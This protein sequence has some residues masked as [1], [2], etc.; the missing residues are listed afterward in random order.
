MT[1]ALALIETDALVIGAGPAGLFQAF[2][3]G[4]LGIGCHIVDVLHEPGGQVAELYGDKPIY[5]IPGL[6]GCT[7]NALITGLREQ[8]RPFNPPMHLGQEVTDL[9]VH[10]EAAFDLRTSH[11]QHFHARSVLIAAGVGAF[12]PRRLKAPGLDAF[13]ST[14]QLLYGQDPRV[15]E[16][17][18]KAVVVAGGDALAIDQ[19]IALADLPEDKRPAAITLMHRRAVLQADAQRLAVFQHLCTSG[20]AKLV[21]G[22]VSEVEVEQKRM[23]ALVVTAPDDTRIHLPLDALVVALGLS[24]RLGPLADWGLELT[25]KQVPVDTAHFMTR[26]PG[27]YAVGDINLYPGKKRLI[28]S[29]F[30]EATLAAFAVAERLY[31]DRRTAL[32]YTSSSSELQQRLGV[33]STR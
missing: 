28:L 4:L 17:A 23:R 22:Q 20:S 18:G 1:S 29:A 3:L 24:P 32:Q 25:H 31:P 33:G 16:C 30:H 6:P 15:F 10:G 27:I 5:D 8:L 9:S 12:A 2:Y 7:G 11:N 13:E 26:I 19:V 21:V 14:N